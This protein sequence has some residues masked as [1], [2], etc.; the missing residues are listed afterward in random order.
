MSVT[1]P[2]PTPRNIVR[3]GSVLA[4]GTIIERLARFGRNVVLARVIAPDQF[5]L[6]AVVLAAIALFEAIT[7]VGVNQ[8]VIQNH[9]GHT[10]EF[11]N[12]A[13]WINAVRGVAIFVIAA[14]LSPA[15]ASFYRQPDLAPLL[16]VAFVSMIFTG[17]ASPRMYALQR[18]FR[19]GASVAVT[20]GAGLLG[21]LATLALGL[22]L[23]N[24]WALVI[25]TV[26]EAALRFLLSFLVCP[27]RPSFR[28]DRESWRDLFRFTRG[29]LGLS[30]LTFLVSQADI[31]VLGRLVTTEVLGLYSMAVTLALFPL[32]VFSKVAQPLV[33]P[34]LA[35]HQDAPDALRATYLRLQRLI[36]LFGL[37]M[38]TTMG[39]AAA[40][41]LELVYGPAYAAASTPFAIISA[42]VVVYMASMVSF[43][44]YL[45]IARPELQRSFTLLRAALL[46]AGIY[47]L[48]VAFGPVGAAASML[49][50][51]TLAMLLQLRNLG[52]VIGLRA[53]PYA[54]TLRGGLLGA[55]VVGALTWPLGLSGWPT[56][57]VALA[58]VV[59]LLVV[60]GV[61]ALRE[62]KELRALRAQRGGAGEGQDG[63]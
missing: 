42:Y 41:L 24:V 43:S 5:G 13:W 32:M 34:L 21:T 51:L 20:Q 10:P 6:M 45:A 52:R 61:A 62:R 33:V 37:P 39:V 59:P 58:S 15:V 22:T 54:A 2:D 36:W 26:V 57:T 4:A 23:R 56:A 11:L 55:A 19:F 27:I 7:E 53:G 47:P 46:V 18:Q 49:G 12:V 14:L 16:T 31:F 17:L 9:R 8:A 63:V 3:G 60:W 29:M 35:A 48:A 38:A 50:A 28:I 40:P 25:G 1:S 44:V 30:F